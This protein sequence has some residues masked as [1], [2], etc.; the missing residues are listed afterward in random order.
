MLVSNGLLRADGWEVSFIVPQ[1]FSNGT[2]AG[3]QSG[4]ISSRARHEI[5]QEVASRIL[6]HCLYPSAKQ[7]DVVASKLVYK[8]PQLADKIGREVVGTGFVSVVFCCSCNS[9]LC[10][11]HRILGQSV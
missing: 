11:K 3:I 8:F 6:N 5:I 10:L 2:M 4:I 1:Q 9:Q 7:F